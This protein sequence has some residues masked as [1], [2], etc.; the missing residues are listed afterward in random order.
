[1]LADRQGSLKLIDPVFVRGREIVRVLA[2]GD[3]ELL[4]EFTRDDLEAF[5]TIPVFAPGPETDALR[6]RLANLPAARV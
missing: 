4:A 5:L 1:V 2:A 3:T 6:G